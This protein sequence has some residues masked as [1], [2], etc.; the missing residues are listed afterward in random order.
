MP[1]R[2][3]SHPL[4]SLVLVSKPKSKIKSSGCH[5]LQTLGNVGVARDKDGFSLRYPRPIHS[6]APSYAMY[7]LRRLGNETDSRQLKISW[8]Q[9]RRQTLSDHGAN[10]TC[11]RWPLPEPMALPLQ[12]SWLRM[13]G[14]LATPTS[15]WLRMRRG[16]GTQEK[17]RLQ[18]SHASFSPS[19]SSHPST[20]SSHSLLE[21]PLPWRPADPSQA[22]ATTWCY[23]QPAATIPKTADKVV[24]VKL[25]PVSGL[26]DSCS[27]GRHGIS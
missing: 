26:A 8:K 4:A 25:V 18:R 12:L 3:A 2:R 6:Q 13:P 14:R 5:L 7:R 24:L 11:C 9:T 23:Y 1:P 19:P 27:I 16:D 20:L 17:P 10:F 15:N 22:T 21:H